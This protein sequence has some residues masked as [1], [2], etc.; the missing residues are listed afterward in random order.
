MC[1]CILKVHGLCLFM[2]TKPTK[3]WVGGRQRKDVFL[4]THV[5]IELTHNKDWA[6]NG[7]SDVRKSGCVGTDMENRR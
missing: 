1:R 2:E 7:G 4:V 5:N 6:Q 3:K